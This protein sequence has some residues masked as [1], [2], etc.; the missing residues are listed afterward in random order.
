M[1]MNQV[2]LETRKDKISPEFAERLD[3]L[4]SR[5]KVGA[6]VIVNG[7]ATRDKTTT[8]R[9]SRANRRYAID[10]KRKA[11]LQRLP[12]IDL[13]LERFG[14]QRLA[15]TPDALGS[16][17]VETTPAGIRA[18]ANSKHVKAILENQRVSLVR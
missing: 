8:R 9:G 2:R 15:K 6:I 18:L 7:L 12:Q 3:R 4:G 13:I 1:G 11:V 14:G 10:D 17:P 16:I 5:Q